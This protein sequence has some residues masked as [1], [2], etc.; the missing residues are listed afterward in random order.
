M[1]KKTKV[2]ISWLL[3][4]Q[5]LPSMYNNFKEYDCVSMWLLNMILRINDK[6][7]CKEDKIGLILMH[8]FSFDFLELD[9]LSNH[10]EIDPIILYALEHITRQDTDLLHNWW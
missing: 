6:I 8:A 4:Y 3:E 9:W 7:D 1:V 2:K 5:I 10:M